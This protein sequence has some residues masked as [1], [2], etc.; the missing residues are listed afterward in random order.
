MSRAALTRVVEF[1]AAHRYHRPDWSAERNA[2]RFGDPSPSP[3]GHDYHCE[4]TIEGDIDPDTGMVIDLP[5][6][7][8]ILQ[9]EVVEPLDHVLLND[10]PDFRGET[11]I[12]T[13][14]N[15]ARVVW[16]RL[17]GRLPRGSRLTR[18]LVREDRALWSEYRG[19]SG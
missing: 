7:D 2:E 17:E 18:V 16:R 4:V 9:G 11:R 3:H 14:E 15:I 12:P 6:L 8:A 10:L 13:T 5:E 1:S 19:P